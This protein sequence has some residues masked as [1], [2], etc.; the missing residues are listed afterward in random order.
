LLE[1]RAVDVRH[2]ADRQVDQGE[3]VLRV[4]VEERSLPVLEL[5]RA[6]KLWILWR[7]DLV[8]DTCQGLWRRRAGF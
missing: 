3:E 2:D 5:G 1:V 4:V 7:A 6:E 8:Q